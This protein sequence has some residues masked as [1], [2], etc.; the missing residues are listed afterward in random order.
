MTIKL[1]LRLAFLVS[2]AF[3]A[4]LT[5]AAPLTPTAL[6]CE[7]LVSP[8]GIDE[9]QP[10]LTWRAES[11]ERGQRQTGYQVLVASHASSLRKNTG[12]LWDSG[13]VSSDQSV[14]VIYAGQPLASR[15]QC[16]W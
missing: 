5:M 10:R 11:S 16:F 12:D 2:L 14:N 6:R 4:Q 9:A 8:L 13:K 3:A 7:Y 15:Q 1:F